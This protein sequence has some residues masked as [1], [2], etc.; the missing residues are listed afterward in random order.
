MAQQQQIVQG[1]NRKHQLRGSENGQI[2][3]VARYIVPNLLD[4]KTRRMDVR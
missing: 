2:N 4:S 1:R 3:R